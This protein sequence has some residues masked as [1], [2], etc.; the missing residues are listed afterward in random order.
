MKE[1]TVSSTVRY[2]P[3]EKLYDCFIGIL[4]GAQGIA[5]IN[6]V[7]RADPA[8]QAAFGRTACA[9]Q[10]TLQDTLDACTPQTIAQLEVAWEE[11]FR[12]HSRAGCHPF[13]REYLLLDIDLTGN[14]CGKKAACA[15]K[16]YFAGQKNRRGRQVG[17]VLATAY[18]EIVVDRLFPGHTVLIGA[19]EA[20]VRAAEETLKL[21]LPRRSRT[22]VRIDAG[23]GSVEAVNGLL[24]R[25]Y[26]VLC[27]DFSTRRARN[28]AKTVTVWYPDPKEAGREV[29]WVEEPATAYVRPVRRVAVRHRKRN[30]Q[31]GIEV[32]IT[33][34]PMAELFGWTG[35]PSNQMGEPQAEL[36][37]ITHSYDQRG[38][39]C[40]TSFRE[41]KQGLGMGKRNKKR[42]EGQQMLVAL[43]AL[44]HNVLVWAKEWLLPTAPRLKKYGVERLVRDVMG[45]LGRVEWEPQ[46]RV[47]RILLTEANPLAHHLL[48]G[49][50]QM[51]AGMGVVVGL[52]PP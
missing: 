23:G 42:F 30:G 24:S 36:L 16:G 3:I 47:S 40:E 34:A 46:Q 6:R 1:F 50:Q 10:S 28:L 4:A 35:T 7:L 19:L 43:G 13:A 21:T 18:R 5:D 44:A 9:E 27:K 11:L 20:M 45:I 33:T 2:T 52:G 49:L 29:G 41:D 38:G 48:P 8:L 37:A 31:F 22:I 14:P 15:T 17:R 39:G 12:L 25:G 26:E 51:V 32:L